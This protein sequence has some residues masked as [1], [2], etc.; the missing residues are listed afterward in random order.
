M[1]AYP[2]VACPLPLWY[3][4]APMVALPAHLGVPASPGGDPWWTSP[5]P[6]WYC[7]D[8]VKPQDSPL[9]PPQRTTTSPLPYLDLR[10]GQEACSPVVVFMQCSGD[11]NNADTVVG[12]TGISERC[13]PLKVFCSVAI[14][15]ECAPSSTPQCRH[16]TA[17]DCMM[18]LSA[19]LCLCACA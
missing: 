12:Q 6:C 2:P 14:L 16:F 18:G 19:F 8:L 17:D 10:E 11:R 5:L 1:Y 7:P 4:P 3:L 13:F 9:P 15:R